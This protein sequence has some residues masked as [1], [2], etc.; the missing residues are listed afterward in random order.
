MRIN[1]ILLLFCLKH[2][3][4]KNVRAGKSQSGGRYYENLPAAAPR[5]WQSYRIGSA[6]TES[7]LP[8]DD[9]SYPQ[10]F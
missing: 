3:K 4:I 9:P 6:A 1:L 2:F 8:V 10:V 5:A 7:P